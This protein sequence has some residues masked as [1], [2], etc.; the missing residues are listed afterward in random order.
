MASSV[1]PPAKIDATASDVA[2][3]L[4]PTKTPTPLSKLLTLGP[5]VAAATAVA[6]IATL[7]EPWVQRVFPLPAMVIALLI[8][9]ALNPLVKASEFQIGLTF[10]V[11]SLLRWAVALLGLR[12]ALHDIIDL[13]LATAAMIVISMTL[14]IVAG[15]LMA[16]L[17][18]RPLASGALAGA[19]T[20]VCGASAAL[21]TIS[22]LPAYKGKDADVVFVVIAVN[23]L[24]TLAMISYPALSYV[25]GFHDKVMGIMLG[26]TIHDVAQVVGAGYA[27]SDT[28]GNS[29][30][31][32]KLFRVFLLMPVVVAIGWY[33]ASQK[34]TTSKSSATVP[35]FAVAFLL[36]CLLNSAPMNPQFA[37]LYAPAKAALAQIS[38]WGLLIAI[39]A[40]GLGTSIRAIAALGWR[41]LSIV[42]VTTVVI[43]VTVSLG[44]LAIY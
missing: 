5:G 9:I 7:A 40:L 44:L 38:T 39:G 24:S 10:C 41:Q 12:I 42:V 35:G 6:I 15:F 30:V 22:V 2:K 16:R 29:A 13:G 17:L 20:A 43:L 28:V 23:L 31:I 25:L 26:A 27:I 19:A 34:N 4:D 1:R 11:K 3:G 36:F 37:S 8:G 32:V 33:F 21:A 14:T 18:G